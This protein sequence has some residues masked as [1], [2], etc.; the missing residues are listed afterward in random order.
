[1][2]G[3]SFPADDFFTAEF[4]TGQLCRRLWQGGLRASP[5]GYRLTASISTLTRSLTDGLDVRFEGDNTVELMVSDLE[6]CWNDIGRLQRACQSLFDV[7][8]THFSPISVSLMQQLLSVELFQP[9]IMTAIVNKLSELG[10][11]SSPHHSFA[12]VLLNQLRWLHF[13]VDGVALCEAL[14]SIIPIVSQP[15]QKCIIEALPEILDD[16]SKPVAVTELI[17]LLEETPA[18]MGSVIDALSM[19]GV[20]PDKLPEVNTSILSTLAAVNRDILPISIKY[21][22]T[23]C[24]PVLYSQTIN[25]LRNVLAL[26]A[27]GPASGKLA[28][29]ALKYSMRSAKS[30]ADHTIKI[31]R[32]LQQP[33]DHKP[34]DIWLMLALYDSPAH[35]KH[36][37]SLFR[38]KTASGMINRPLLDAALAP[39]AQAFAHLS[40]SLATLAAIAV[41]SSD[42]HS[43]RTGVFLYSLLFRMYSE[44]D[45]RRNVIAALIDHVGTRR[46]G[47]V[48]TSLDALISIATEGEHDRSLLPHSASV[49]RLLDFLEFFSDPQLRRLWTV[50][51]LLCRASARKV[52]FEREQRNAQLAQ[53][54]VDDDDV[55]GGGELQMLEILLEKE[56]THTDLFYRRVG[57]IGSCTMIKVLAGKVENKILKMMLDVGKSNSVSQAMAFDELAEVFSSD[58]ISESVVE[59]I[60]QSISVRFESK[61]LRDRNEVTSMVKSEK[62]FSAE[63][64]GNLEGD[65]CELC[66]SIA[67]LIRNEETM[68]QA[69]DAARSM[70]PNLRLLCVLTS[71]RFK[72]SLSEVDAI[73]GAPLHIPLLPQDVDMDDVSSDTKEELLLNLFIAHGWIIELI[74]GFARQENNEL[75]AKCISRIDNLLDISDQIGK[76]IPQTPRW[77]QVLYDSY[78][79]TTQGIGTNKHGQA[80]TI[81]QTSLKRKGGKEKS[82]IQGTKADRSEEW[83]RFSRL[84]NA[85]ALSLIRIRNPITFRHTETED[86]AREGQP[87]LHSIELSRKGLR[88][89]LSELVERVETI[90][91]GRFQSTNV[92]VIALFPSSVSSKGDDGSASRFAS[93]ENGLTQLRKLREALESVGIQL[94]R[95]FDS[96]LTASMSDEAEDEVEKVVNRECVMLCLQSLVITFCSSLLSDVAARDLLFY[97][98]ASVRMDGKL[99]IEASDPMTA[100]DVS[101]AAKTGFDQLLNHMTEVVFGGSNNNAIDDA[102]CQVGPNLLEFEGCC[103]MLAAM[104]SMFLHCSEQHQKKI[105]PKLSNLAHAVMSYP[106][107]E[108]V[109]R[110]RQTQKL[111][112]GLIRLYVQYAADP[113]KVAE[114][115]R[116]E[117]SKVSERLAESKQ[118]GVIGTQVVAGGR[119]SQRDRLGSL[120]EQTI[121]AYT[122]AI[123]DQ[124][125]WLFKR[126]KPAG[127]DKVED[128]FAI[129]E[130]LIRAELPLYTL[131]RLNQRMLGPVMRAGRTLVELFLKICLPFLKQ[132][133]GDHSAQVV[134][135]CR[136]HQKPTR[137]LQTFCAHSKA[138]RDTSLTGLVPPLRKSL[139]L[140]L[141]RVKEILQIHNAM[142]AFQLGNLKH[143]DIHGEVVG[144]QDSVYNHEDGA[145][146]DE[147]PEEGDDENQG[148]GDHD[149]DNALAEENVVVI[150][151]EE[152][153]DENLGSGNNGRTSERRS[154]PMPEDR[155]NVIKKRRKLQG[156][157][158]RLERSSSENDDKDEVEEVE[159][160]LMCDDL[161]LGV[162]SRS[163][164]RKGKNRD[165][166]RNNIR[167]GADRRAGS[168]G[169][170]RSGNSGNRFENIDYT[171]RVRCPLI[172]DEAG[173]A[174]GDEDCED[175]YDDDLASQFVLNDDEEIE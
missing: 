71:L 175:Y 84:L 137:V 105:G 144:S 19:L 134:Q 159:D 38:R 85:G 55:T 44:G 102:E 156:H 52:G 167:R 162:I 132:K 130:R 164:H 5:D 129:M 152:D 17:K 78:N 14:L 75:R 15:L 131:A 145:E 45:V 111:L 123:L 8:D 36:V 114:G 13:L 138:I 166:G 74:N 88:Y 98:L 101:V 9:P 94:R 60:R 161:P 3:K 47:E 158:T 113:L 7:Q 28:I 70:V 165:L 93:A 143:R 146:G 174:D 34:S 69:Q 154:R 126:L 77:S 124:Y 27:L 139:E 103:A 97:I 87:M 116:E 72:G 133:F 122:I 33:T 54:A 107:S 31:L 121:Y 163:K 24:P 23:T 41:K 106:W 51:G 148:H 4:G 128:A 96:L 147:A 76:L 119:A 59:D 20:A 117:I 56:L 50:M 170:R 125:V 115:L 40:K 32:G 68:K 79:G 11:D 25:A 53:S 109:M 1:M 172:D 12:P 91:S 46:P 120:A 82:M 57:V 30:V 48:E 26:P 140:L 173:E 127:Y 21:L 169:T 160:N 49:Q 43:Q 62:F 18:L 104:D 95:C 118:H 110:L 64:F 73:I 151:T 65:E 99:P 10:V 63:L 89:L 150:L 61:Y 153:D 100:E 108:S 90:V 135:I 22:L 42:F 168:S 157:N 142:G 112:P 83:R 81:G 80:A 92:F 171:Q 39:F 6:T 86:I 149:V 16:E 37:E 2:R 58:V 67:S 35:R 29:D 155:K 136:S 66:F 141:Y